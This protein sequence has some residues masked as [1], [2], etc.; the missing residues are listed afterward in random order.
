MIPADKQEAFNR[1]WNEIR[2]PAF[3]NLQRTGGGAPVQV[4]QCCY[5][6]AGG[7]K[8]AIGIFIPDGHPAQ[9]LSMSVSRLHSRHPDL[10]EDGADVPFLEELQDCHDRPLREAKGGDFRDAF[11]THMRELAKRYTLT[12]PRGV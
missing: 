12:I 3:D 10:F 5:L 8:C 1:A 11:E 9:S 7:A 4:I 2:E 6:A